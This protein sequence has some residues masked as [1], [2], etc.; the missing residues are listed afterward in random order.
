MTRKEKN[1]AAFCLVLGA[2]A[3]AL[4]G[5]WLAQFTIARTIVFFLACI[6]VAA[7][8]YPAVIVILEIRAEQRREAS[9]SYPANWGW[10]KE[11]EN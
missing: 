3:G 2:I 1:I 8:A 4:V 5:G 10:D 6:G 9:R 11:F 7:M